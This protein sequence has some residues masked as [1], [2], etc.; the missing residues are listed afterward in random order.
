MVHLPISACAPSTRARGFEHFATRIHEILRDEGTGA[1]YVFDCLSE[2]LSAWTTDHMVGNFFWVTCPYL[3]ELDT[4]AY[5]A[6]IR[7]SHSFENPR[8]ASARPLRC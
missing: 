7:H 1:F 8:P 3:F 5:F 4:V 2:L 6:L